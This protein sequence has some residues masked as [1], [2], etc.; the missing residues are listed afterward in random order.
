MDDRRRPNVLFVICDQLR[1]DHLGFAGNPVVRTPNLDALAACGTVFDRA[2]VNN[3]VCMPNR[4]TMMTGRL[5]SAHG[6]VF[7]DRSLPLNAETFVGRLRAE[8]W[9]TGLIG[10]SHLQHGESRDS[11]KPLDHPGMWSPFEEG[12]DTVEKLSGLVE[13]WRSL[14]GLVKPDVLVAQSAPTALVAAQG[15]G[16]RTVVIGGGYDNPPLANP[17]PL[18]GLG[19][20]EDAS[21]HTQLAKRHEALALEKAN[22]VLPLFGHQKVDRFCDLIRPDL[23]LLMCWPFNDHYG[24]RSKLEPDHP[25]HLGPIFMRSRG[26]EYRWDDQKGGTKIFAYLRPSALTAPVGLRALAELGPRHNIICAAPG[27]PEVPLNQLRERGVQ[28][29]PGPVLMEP[30]LAECDIGLSHAS[31]GVGSAFLS[32]GIRQV[33]LPNHRE[34]AMFARNLGKRGLCVGIEGKY[35]AD[36][37][38]S[39]VEKLWLDSAAL[40]RVKAA[41]E[42]IRERCATDPGQLAAQ[43]IREFLG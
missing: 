11:V 2:Y 37:V 39:C 43:E 8:G 3:P 23:S 30:L 13:A 25:P 34:Q 32:A 17:M 24:D 14:I 40:G 6:V 9:I 7:N 41:A 21:D 20:E 42:V 38:V 15:L 1:A 16:L 19:R 22:A 12:W 31:S 18:F 4:S 36:A 10:K 28:V 26:A 35:G 5:P 27:L 33:G 29:E